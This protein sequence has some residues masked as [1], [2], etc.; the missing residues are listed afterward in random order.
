MAKFSI[1]APPIDLTADGNAIRVAP[2]I[3]MAQPNNVII[4]GQSMIQ[5]L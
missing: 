4:T 2:P 5:L 1:I 3:I